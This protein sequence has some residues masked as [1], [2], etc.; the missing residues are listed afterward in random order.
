MLLDSYHSAYRLTGTWF[1]WRSA[2]CRL[3][4]DCASNELTTKGKRNGLRMKRQ[5]SASFVCKPFLFS[6]LLIFPSVACFRC[7]MLSCAWQAVA[8]FSGWI[9][10]ARG[11][12]C[13]KRLCRL[14]LPLL[15]EPC[16]TF[17]S[18]HRERVA[19]GMNLNY[20]IGCRL[21]HKKQTM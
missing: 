3:P 6:C 11:R 20:T 15:S 10:S 5:N 19:D 2:V 1:S 9:R 16:A 8:R 7:R 14:T 13:P 12:F 4:C 18:E 17:A 21:C